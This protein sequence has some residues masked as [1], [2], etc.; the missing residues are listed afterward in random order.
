M[1][2]HNLWQGQ[3]VRLRAF[4]PQDWV[5]FSQWDLD[6]DTA[7]DCYWVPFPKSQEAARKWAAERALAEPKS[8]AFDFV[9][10]NLAGE[11]VGNINS[12]C[13]DGR[14]GT[15]QYGLAIRREHWRK[16]YAAEAIC[17][18]L[19]YYFQELRYQKVTVEVYAF[20]E[21]SIKLHEK[22]GF[23]HEGRMRR[24]IFT[25]G[26]YHDVLM[27]GMTAEEFAEARQHAV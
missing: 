10:E 24:M 22:L 16:G 4:E 7:R 3:R 6:S 13:C 17:L 1:S 9:I 19:R 26:Q 8:D 14:N 18:L 5:V 20:N 21:A 11:L 27:L 15:F 25:H 2:E 12:L 23:V